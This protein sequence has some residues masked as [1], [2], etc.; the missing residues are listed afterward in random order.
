MKKQI[1]SSLIAISFPL[2]SYA[3]PNKGA[4]HGVA[5]EKSQNTAHQARLLASNNTDIA[6]KGRIK[7]KPDKGQL[8]SFQ[9]FFQH[10]DFVQSLIAR[11][12][13]E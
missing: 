8:G 10:H 4:N 13:S 6:K 9:E 2:S 7:G 12:Y 5:L 1:I 11:V 3:L